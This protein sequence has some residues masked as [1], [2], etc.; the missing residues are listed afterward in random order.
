MKVC[1]N[2]SES[3]HFMLCLNWQI[4]VNF[5]LLQRF[6]VLSLHTNICYKHNFI[7]S[8]WCCYYVLA[9]VCPVL[10]TFRRQVIDECRKQGYL[11][12][13][14]GRRRLFPTIRSSD[15]VIRTHAERQ[16]INFVI[17]GIYTRP[18]NYVFNAVCQI[19]IFR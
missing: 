8:I 13:V 7:N 10:H 6:Q 15:V 4:N 12:T 19:R 3:L 16:A 18:S 14:G 11:F 1:N 5:M 17:Q 9:D 2:E